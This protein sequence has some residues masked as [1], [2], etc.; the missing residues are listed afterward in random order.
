MSSDDPNLASL[1]TEFGERFIGE[2]V[3]YSPDKDFL[4]SD[5]GEYTFSQ[6]RESLSGESDWKDGIWLDGRFC[7]HQFWGFPNFCEVSQGK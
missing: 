4:I 6:I 7:Y 3:F 1:K 5:K 2:G